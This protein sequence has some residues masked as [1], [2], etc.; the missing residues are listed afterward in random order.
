ML[1]TVSYMEEWNY[2]LLER[3]SSHGKLYVLA[4]FIWELSCVFRFR[5][6]QNSLLF[7][8]FSVLTRALSCKVFFSSLNCLNK[9]QGIVLK[10]SYNNSLSICLLSPFCTL[11]FVTILPV[12]PSPS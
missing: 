10:L 3:F 4:L 12:F 2:L 5:L 1:L 6:L 9:M 8:S 7:V 11:I